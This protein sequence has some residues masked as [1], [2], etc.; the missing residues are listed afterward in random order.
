MNIKNQYFLSIL[1]SALKVLMK[2]PLCDHCLGRLYAK[3][4]LEL[5]NDERGRAIKTLLLMFLYKKYEENSINCEELYKLAVNAGDPITRLYYKLCGGDKL[6]QHPC[7]ICGAKISREYFYKLAEKIATELKS[8]N[9]YK[10]VVGV[11]LPEDI[12]L[13]EIEVYRNTGLE[14]SE[15]I[16]N[17]IKRETGKI[18]RDLHGLIPEFKEPEAM[19]IVNYID[20]SITIIVNPI[21]LEG[22]YWKRGRNISHVPWTD[23]YGKKLYPYS[24]YDFFNESLREVYEADEVVIHASGREDVDARMLGEG[25]PLVVEIRNPRFRYVD[26]DLVNE[27]LKSDLIEAVVTSRASRS[28]I[29][30][31]KEFSSKK[32]KAYKLLIMSEDPLDSD[33]LRSLEEYF[34]NRLINQYTPTRI[35]RRKKERLRIKRVHSVKTM[36]ITDHLFEALIYCDGGLYVKELVHGDRGRTTP[37]F[38]EFLGTVLYPLEIDVFGVEAVS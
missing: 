36:L 31:L 28:R 37:S 1:E 9:A 27:L 15:S 10:F 17:E 25:R 23:R 16:K 3:L 32:R 8:I 34:S 7:Y 20:D 11:S 24:L 6:E 12:A 38:A 14:L 5:G 18:I 29:K 19:A 30:Y 33:Q 26:L 2:Y 4:G 35:L 13:K 21:L 22:R